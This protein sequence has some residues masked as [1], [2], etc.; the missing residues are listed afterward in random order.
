MSEIEFKT[1]V[2]EEG[3]SKEAKESEDS[4]EHPFLTPLFLLFP[5]LISSPP[6]VQPSS[7]M[8]LKNLHRYFCDYLYEER[9]Q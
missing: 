1:S 4:K 9:I 5:I 3:E 8:K 7:V 6:F 2:P